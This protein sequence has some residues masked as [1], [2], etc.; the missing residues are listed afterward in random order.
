M[1]YVIAWET[2][3]NTNEDMQERGLKVFSNWQPD[4]KVQFLEFLG[5]VDQRGGFAIVETKDPALVARDMATFGPFFNFELYP[6]L[7]IQDTA[8]ISEK[9][10]Q[11]RHTV[12]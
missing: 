10:I 1:K 7:D 9:A 4:K 6:V 5:R 12:S 2:R 3:D 8:A 11:F